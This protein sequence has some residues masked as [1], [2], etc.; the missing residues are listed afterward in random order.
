MDFFI[1]VVNNSWFIGIAGGIVSSLATYWLS[2]LFFSNKDN[3]EY[4]QKTNS[5]NNEIIYALR[6]GISEGCLPKREVILRL[7][8]ATCRKKGVSVKDAY[9]YSEIIED[10]TKEVMD[11]SF[12]SSNNKMQYCDLLSSSLSDFSIAEKS[13]IESDNAS[14]TAATARDM[15]TKNITEFSVFFATVTGLLT[16]MMTLISSSRDKF[17]ILFEMFGFLRWVAPIFMIIISLFIAIFVIT[18]IK[19]NKK[20]L[21]ASSDIKQK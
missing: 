8:K 10:L 19:K 13:I 18:T 16:L 6:L 5:V 14:T 2:R 1:N 15:R 20:T 4:L 11:S 3:K 7:I 9:S 21:I 17:N 12:I